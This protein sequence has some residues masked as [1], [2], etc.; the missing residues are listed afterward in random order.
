MAHSVW[1]DTAEARLLVDGL[2]DSHGDVRIAA[3]RAVSRMPLAP[4]DWARV[5]AYASWALDSSLSVAEQVA[6]ID[7]SPY[8]PLQSLRDLVTRVA[9]ERQGE[10]W[11]HAVDAASKFEDL[12]ALVDRPNF[13]PVV[14]RDVVAVQRL[15][16]TALSAGVDQLRS[17]IRIVPDGSD[18]G[19]WLAVVLASH[20]EDEHLKAAFAELQQ[21]PDYVIGISYMGVLAILENALGGLVLPTRTREWLSVIAAN[22]YSIRASTVAAALLE[23]IDS[24]PVDPPR[25]RGDVTGFVSPVPFAKRRASRLASR[26]NAEISG[27]PLQDDVWQ[28][29]R[30]WERDM[31]RLL[32]SGLAPAV[33]TAMFRRAVSK[34]DIVLGNAIVSSVAHYQNDFHPDLDGLFRLYWRQSVRGLAQDPISWD[35]PSLDRWLCWQVAWTV[36]RG[37]LRGLASGLAARFR[38]TRPT[39]RRAAALL[40]AD[41]AD[42]LTRPYGPEFYEPEFYEPDTIPL[43]STGLVLP[44]IGDPSGE[45]PLGPPRRVVIQG[46]VSEAVDGGPDDEAAKPKLGHGAYLYSVLYATNRKPVDASDPSRGFTNRRDDSD[47]VR[48]GICEVQIPKAHHFGTTGTALYRRVLKLHFSDDRLKVVRQTKIDAV[49][50]F[51]FLRRQLAG[52]EEADRVLLVYLH[53]YNVSFGEAAVRAAQIGFDLKVPGATAF[54]SW[55]SCGS[56]RAYLADADRIAA[57]E[58]Q[59]ADFLTQ[60][61]RMTGARAVHIIAHSMGNRGF[62]RAIQRITAT[63]SAQG[64]VRF[65]QIVLAAPD[66]EVGLFRDLAAIYPSISDHTTMYVSARD[67]AL[68]LSKHLQKSD[69][70]GYTPPVTIVP[71]ID[72]IEVTDIDISMLG[73]TYYAQAAPVLYDID[74]LLWH[75]TPA[76][77]RV[78]L[79]SVGQ[80]PARY[81]RV[82]P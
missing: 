48:Y 2:F 55:P 26:L 20:D 29:W 42:C 50:F 37:G 66:I 71:E 22:R 33:V 74:E 45:S 19:F 13:P 15:A 16:G 31:G 7:A 61:S 46:L 1:L 44:R 40:I 62:A 36:S 59:I 70:A 82:R 67:H 5:A 58:K 79:E 18:V 35:E 11:S 76:S 27:R 77:R 32:E 24:S 72:T 9:E 6:V 53:G 54:F 10:A 8:M 14:R 51:D 4:S 78:R 49:H 30:L 12:S 57:S 34:R 56:A 41:A 38:S 75:N 23:A 21:D 63:A 25:S 64:G 69:R 80:P 28:R 60:T 17:L 39:E 43:E 81:W 47:A 73:H 68:A 52:L 65:G 3:L